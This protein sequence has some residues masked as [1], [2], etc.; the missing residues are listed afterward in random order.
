MAFGKGDVVVNTALKKQSNRIRRTRSD[1]VFDTVNIVVM[2]VLCVLVL[3]PFLY[4]ISMSIGGSVRLSASLI[5]AE[6][7]FSG[8]ERV[9]SNRNLLN[10]FFNSVFRTV[11]G[12]ILTLIVTIGAA[13]A[14][15]KRRLPNKGMWTG[16][17]VFTMFFSG[18]LIPSYLL[19]KSLGLL[20]NRFAMILPGLVSTYNMIIMRNFFAAVPESMEE[21]AMIDGANDVIILVRIIIPTSLAIVATVGLWTAV[22]HWN[23]W[24]DC[25]IYIQTTSKQVMQLILRRIVLEGTTTLMEMN[26]NA[27]D[28]G[29][30]PAES[31]KAATIVVTTLPIIVVYPFLQ[32]YFVKGVMVGSLKG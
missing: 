32:K 14:L 17:A 20:D 26:V 9:F 16:I 4:I 29:N 12:T 8:Y 11:V 21:S 24:F 27:E 23:A 6:L 30:A 25:M 5:P 10:G 31:I 1:V 19:V 13:Y 15:S 18:G 28:F 7:S 22:G 2:L 3:Y